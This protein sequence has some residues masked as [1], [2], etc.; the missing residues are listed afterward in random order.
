MGS[1]VLPH[2]LP[3]TCYKTWNYQH[4]SSQDT[5]IIWTDMAI[6]DRYM[7]IYTYISST[8][9]QTCR[10]TSDLHALPE[11]SG[12]LYIYWCIQLV[13]HFFVL[14]HL[15]FYLTHNKN[16]SG[17]GLQR[18]ANSGKENCVK[19]SLWS[20]YKVHNNNTIMSSTTTWQGAIITRI[21]QWWP[22]KHKNSF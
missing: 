22:L 12:Y 1:I 15:Q 13:T 18:V 5:E 2:W 6:Y 16:Q 11:A 19:G 4:E 17:K 9:I 7:G 21:A 20:T 10:V 8:N 14:L 3:V